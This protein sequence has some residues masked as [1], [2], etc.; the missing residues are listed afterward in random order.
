M[1]RRRARGGE[2]SSTTMARYDIAL[3][4]AR[5]DAR[6]LTLLSEPLTYHGGVGAS[7]TAAAALAEVPEDTVSTVWEPRDPVDLALVLGQLGRGAGDPTLQWDRAGRYGPAGVWRT[8]RTPLGAATLHLAQSAAGSVH[9]RA[10]GAGAEWAIDGVPELLG[11]GDD[12]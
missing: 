6:P 12:P 9:A 8:L 1:V 11:A 7:G 5:H 10:W 4:P 3:P 2:P